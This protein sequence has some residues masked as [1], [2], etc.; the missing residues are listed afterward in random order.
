MHQQNSCQE[1][2]DACSNN[3]G[4]V[5]SVL[6]A[7][8]CHKDRQDTTTE[9]LYSFLLNKKDP[10]LIP[11]CKRSFAVILQMAPPPPPTHTHTHIALQ[12]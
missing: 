6:V 8:Y 12:L 10:P 11:P 7:V 9:M 1:L 5:H 3:C 2:T 4:S